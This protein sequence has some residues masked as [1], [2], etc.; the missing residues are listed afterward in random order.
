MLSSFCKVDRTSN[1]WYVDVNLV[2][3]QKMQKTGIACVRMLNRDLHLV[4]NIKIRHFNL[5]PKMLQMI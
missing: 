2:Q 3:Y 4:H 5:L 1:M